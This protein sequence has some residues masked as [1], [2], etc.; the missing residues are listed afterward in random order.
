MILAIWLISL[1]ALFCL[2]NNIRLAIAVI[3]TATVFMKDVWSAL[4]VPPVIA[5]IAVAWWIIWVIFFVFV[6][7]VGDI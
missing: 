6:Y 5:I 4:L 2:W 7:S 1:I 3:K